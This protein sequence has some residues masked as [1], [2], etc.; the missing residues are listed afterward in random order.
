MKFYTGIVVTGIM[1]SVLNGCANTTDQH[2]LGLQDFQSKTLPTG[3]SDAA[4]AAHKM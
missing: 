1:L 3:G 2:T 4:L